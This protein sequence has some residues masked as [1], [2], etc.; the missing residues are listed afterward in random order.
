MDGNHFIVVEAVNNGFFIIID[1]AIGKEQ[2]KKNEL[3]TRYLCGDNQFGYVLEL[4]ETERMKPIARRKHKYSLNSLLSYL[5]PYKKELFVLLLS[6]LIGCLAQTLL[7]ILTQK[8]VDVGIENKNLSALVI[9]LVGEAML[10]FS[11]SIASL[12]QGWVIMFVGARIN[13]SLVFEILEKLVKLPMRFFDSRRTG[14]ILT[15]V[16]DQYKIE[17]FLT[18]SSI[19]ITIS[20]LSFLVFSLMTL[21]YSLPV[22]FI[23]LAGNAFYIIWT[24]HFLPRRRILDFET[25]K[26]MSDS[27]DC[28]IETVSGMPEIKLNSYYP[29]K[30]KEW[31]SI[32]HRTYKTIVAN[33]KLSQRQEYGAALISELTNVV[34]L[35]FAAYQVI[36][37]KISLGSMLALQYITGQ[38]V[39]PIQNSVGLIHGL[40]D[41]SIAYERQQDII[42]QEEEDSPNKKNK[43]FSH[44]NDDITI[45]DVTFSYEGAISPALR[46]INLR[47]PAGKV[48]AIVGAS[49]SGKSTL[50]KMLLGFYRPDSGEI[51]VNDSNLADYN[52]DSWRN[53]CGAV[54]QGGYIFSETI[55]DNIIQ[56]CPFDTN[57]FEQVTEITNVNDFVQ[58]LPLGYNTTIGDNGHGLSL[59]QRQRILIARA[60]Y[61]NPELLLFDEATNSLDARNEQEIWTRLTETFS[62]RTVIVSAH[63]LST[64]RFADQILVMKEGNVV[65]SGCHDSLMAMKGE[66]YR[67]VNAQL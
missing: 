61:K 25:F 22:F 16:T 38:M 23:M 67:L 53:R 35:F 24:V 47:I 32:Q 57:L 12:V 45:I 43:N 55:T 65:E 62:G 8:V 11:T 4:K 19:E 34:I 37:G 27:Q 40:Q 46:N 7:P 3:I 18:H 52:I 31:L 49:G 36:S 17:N 66:Y 15:R 63:R 5:Q 58:S 29:K 13:A 21:Y 48:T 64:I 33:T 54:L 26:N 39:A 60:L 9:I 44:L 14:D 51:R 59:G 10:V 1:P 6:L 56:N 28:I 2:L 30:S 50:V 20:C 41:A 42:K